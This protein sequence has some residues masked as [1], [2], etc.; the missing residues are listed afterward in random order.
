MK[1]MFYLYQGQTNLGEGASKS[2]SRQVLWNWNGFFSTWEGIYVNSMY[3][4]M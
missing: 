4:L 1:N 3:K 2:F